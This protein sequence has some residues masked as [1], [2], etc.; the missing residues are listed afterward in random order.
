MKISV[1]ARWGARDQIKTGRREREKKKHIYKVTRVDETCG[2]KLKR[3]SL[4][5][6]DWRLDISHVSTGPL[7][8][9]VLMLK[10]RSEIKDQQKK[11]Q[12]TTKRDNDHLCNTDNDVAFKSLKL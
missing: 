5:A 4:V 10:T 1:D 9:R 3:Q 8:G 2:E 6:S 12:P 7:R 11:M